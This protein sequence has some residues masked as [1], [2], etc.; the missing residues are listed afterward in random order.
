MYGNKY[1]TDDMINMLQYIILY[2]ICI[3]E[4]IIHCI[5]FV[6]YS[7]DGV[8]KFQTVEYVSPAVYIKLL[9]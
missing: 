1:T 8:R 5:N 4:T 3:V 7:L 2:P 6:M 9:E